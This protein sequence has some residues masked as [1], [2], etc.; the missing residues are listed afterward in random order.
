M[1]GVLSPV[2]ERVDVD[3]TELGHVADGPCSNPRRF[4]V[5]YDSVPIASIT[6]ST[7]GAGRLTGRLQGDTNESDR[8]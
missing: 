4:T 8:R 6:H 1:E 5:D 7:L 3:R 2:P